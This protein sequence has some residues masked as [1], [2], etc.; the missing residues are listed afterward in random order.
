[1]DL[2][3]YFQKNKS[4][5]LWIHLF[6]SFIIK[7]IPRPGTGVTVGEKGNIGLP[8]L[9]GDKGDRGFPGIQ[10]PPGLPGPPGKWDCTVLNTLVFIVSLLIH[11]YSIIILV[12]GWAWH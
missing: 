5:P 10:G 6:F 7:V 11:V 9:P 8:G 4:L 2:P 1:M 12:P 3:G